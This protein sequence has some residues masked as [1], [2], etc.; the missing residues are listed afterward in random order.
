MRFM[1]VLSLVAAFACCTPVDTVGVT[2]TFKYVTCANVF[3]DIVYEGQ[4]AVVSV[5]GGAVQLLEPSG[6]RVALVNTS[7]LVVMGTQE[8]YE[9]SRKDH[10]IAPEEDESDESF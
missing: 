5:T 3:G 6:L 4:A 1:F 8:E 7:C 2:D 10:G 9:Q